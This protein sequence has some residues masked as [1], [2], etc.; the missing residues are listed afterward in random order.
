M[1]IYIKIAINFNLD[2]YI[3]LL[4]KLILKL[5]TLF[6]SIIKVMRLLYSKLEADNNLFAIYHLFYKE[7]PEII[8]LGD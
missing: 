1:Q 7:K 5:S 6:D 3:W 8:K 4:F 2:F